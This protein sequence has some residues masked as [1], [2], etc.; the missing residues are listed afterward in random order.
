[1]RKFERQ[2]CRYTAVFS[3][4]ACNTCCKIASRVN[5]KV[6]A[7]RIT[8]ALFVFDPDMDFQRSSDHPEESKDKVLHVFAA[9]Q[10]RT[11]TSRNI[12]SQFPFECNL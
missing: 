3:Y 10:R 9:H 6:P 1:M 11:K 12:T 7:N 8:G 2:S 5:E 4:D